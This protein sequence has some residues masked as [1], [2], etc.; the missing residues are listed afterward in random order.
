[1]S[2]D[3]NLLVT[4]DRIRN[5]DL[6]TFYN[7]EGSPKAT[8]DFIAHFVTVDGEYPPK[9]E[10]VKRVLS[11]RKLADLEEISQQLQDAMEMRAVP[12]V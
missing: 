6:E 9:N 11:G 8:I 12:K 7:V 1:M 10:A 2:D 5:M 4:E 3:L